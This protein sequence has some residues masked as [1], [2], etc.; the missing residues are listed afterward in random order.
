M[1]VEEVVKPT[2]KGKGRAK[3]KNAGGGKAANEEAPTTN[4]ASESKDGKTEKRRSLAVEEKYQK[5]TQREHII[6]R[7]DT[8]S[9]NA[10]DFVME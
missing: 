1:E 9:R 4:A 10:T 3:G 6:K 7:P 8:Y 2:S 5:M